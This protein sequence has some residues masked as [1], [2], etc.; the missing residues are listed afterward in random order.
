MKRLLI[1]SLLA[2]ILIELLIVPAVSAYGTSSPETWNATEVTTS[3]SV[4]TYFA[5]DQYGGGQS[6]SLYMAMI[7]PHKYHSISQIEWTSYIGWESGLSNPVSVILVYQDD[8]NKVVGQGLMTYTANPPEQNKYTFVISSWNYTYINTKL[9]EKD[10]YFKEQNTPYN[11][12]QYLQ[13]WLLGMQHPGTAPLDSIA[14]SNTQL[15]RNQTCTID[16][17]TWWKNVIRRESII[18]D[19]PIGPSEDLLYINKT[20]YLGYFGN[21]TV[22]IKD[23]ETGN[24]VNTST[25]GET[26]LTFRVKVP[27]YQIII[28]WKNGLAST[29]NI[30]KSG[31]PTP[32][33][34]GSPTP[35]PTGPTPT[36]TQTWI[37]PNESLMT[38]HPHYLDIGVGEPDQIEI[39]G[40][41]SS[42]TCRIEYYASDQVYGF[43]EPYAEFQKVGGTWHKHLASDGWIEH[44]STWA[45][46]NSYSIKWAT[47]GKKSVSI[48]AWDCSGNLIDEDRFDVMVEVEESLKV[49][50][51]V[52]VYDAANPQYHIVNAVLNITDNTAEISAGPI[53]LPGGHYAFDAVRGDSYTF[54]ATYLDWY[55]D[56]ITKTLSASGLNQYEQINLYLTPPLE[57]VNYT[58][59]TGVLQVW[60]NT[61]GIRIPVSGVSITLGS[62]RTPISG[63]TVFPVITNSEGSVSVTLEK[64]IY[65]AFLFNKPGYKGLSQTIQWMSGTHE[66]T[67]EKIV[68]KPTANITQYLT[69]TPYPTRTLAPGERLLPNGTIVRSDGSMVLPNGTIIDANGNII[70]GTAD[71][72]TNQQKGTAIIDLLYTHGEELMSL[73]IFA[74]AMS[75]LNIATGGLLFSFLSGGK[76]G[77]RRRKR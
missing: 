68:M 25:L 56:E 4:A 21:S 57:D 14:T 27:S 30:Y 62:N 20:F 53:V 26:N 46:A 61:G 60:E 33:P 1:F 52:D 69:Q 15:I 59:M 55:P 12:Q 7:E 16:Y 13:P 37:N 73:A 31:Y 35:T 19:P 74:T 44:S 10:M 34:T 51:Y 70:N 6:G 39:L 36:P 8:N 42:D 72:R 24:I 49:S 67:M 22:E 40:L 41:N 5:L 11:N 3:T 76:S 77:G 66:V 50:T 38:E 48:A 29:F 43:E 28:T 58:N 71:F 54:S 17:T 23:L 18:T 2:L 64:D 9:W 47:G 32:T 65:Y 63:N 45:E 75:L